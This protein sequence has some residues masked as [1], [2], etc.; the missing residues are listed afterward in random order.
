MHACMHTY[1]I[2]THTHT[3]TWD[4]ILS[5][6]LCHHAPSNICM[7]MRRV[8]QQLS[9][10]RRH[11]DPWERFACRN[12]YMHTRLQ[13]V[14]SVVAGARVFVCMRTPLRDAH[15]RV[16]QKHSSA[17]S[18]CGLLAWAKLQEKAQLRLTA[19]TL[20]DCESAVRCA[21]SNSASLGV[22]DTFLDCAAVRA[23]PMYACMIPHAAACR[24]VMGAS[25][26]CLHTRMVMINTGF[27][28]GAAASV[29]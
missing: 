27:P 15:V 12:R 19:C 8:V 23:S 5:S 6:W 2:H 29:L 1:I 25:C 4:D 7:N 17:Q 21:D 18:T 16:N 28:R 11:L 22:K 24:M 9:R 13:T 26:M 3:Q 10:L 14:R 20:R